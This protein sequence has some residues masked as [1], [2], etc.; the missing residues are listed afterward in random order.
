MKIPDK[1]K[2]MKKY[3]VLFC[4]VLVSIVV[5]AVLAGY[6]GTKDVV[7]D[8]PNKV[9]KQFKR[10]E[11]WKILKKQ[12]NLTAIKTFLDYGSFFFLINVSVSCFKVDIWHILFIFCL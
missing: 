7:N 8:I 3:M 12:S 11:E 2:G 5:S 6:V 9:E 4:I 10:M 1:S